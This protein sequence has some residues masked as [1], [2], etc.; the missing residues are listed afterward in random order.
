MKRFKTTGLCNPAK[1]YMVDISER[2]AQ[3]KKMVDN[4][5]YFTINRARQFGK[6]TTLAALKKYLSDQYTVLNLDFQSMSN[7]TFRTEGSFIKAFAL[8]LL[9]KAEINQV[10]IPEGII[11][12]FRT[13]SVT[14]EAV[15]DLRMLFT[16]FIRWC[17]FS[18]KQIVV[19]IDEVDSASNNQVFLD[20]LAQ[21]RLMYL[22]REAN[23]DYPAFQS[24]ILAGVTDI[25]HLKS[26]IRDEDQI[27]VNSPWNIAAD[28]DI[29]MTLSAAGIKGMLDDY[30]SDH[31]T[32]MDTK[33]IADRI[34]KYTF[35][36]PFLVS[37]ICQLIDEKMVPDRFDS[38]EDAWTD[39]GFD[40]AIKMLLLEDNSLFD[41]LTGKL[42]NYPL[43]REKLKGILLRGNTLEYL[44]DDE[45]QKQL[46]MYG[47]VRNYHNTCV[48]FNRIFEMRLY[49]Q[50]LGESRYD[51][52]KQLGTSEKSVFIENGELNVPKIM[53]HFINSQKQIHDEY[54][55]KFAEEEGR[56][57]FL[58][59]LS[60]IIN[61]VGTY[62]IEEQTRDHRRMDIVIHYLGKRYVIELKIWRGNSY[63]EKGE[64][65]LKGYLDFFGLDVGYLLSFNF[66]KKKRSGVERI[67]IGDKTIFEGTV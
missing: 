41:S 58:T 37:R 12:E 14:D 63:N 2:L 27:K 15:L 53:E 30:E 34:Y 26:R 67:K 4:G 49:K 59:Y 46:R 1:D 29:D 9:E 65:Q 44:P 52:L 48:V 42:T 35:G 38:L 43:L 33:A 17:A 50:F 45:A 66:N 18:D 51:D 22:E 25:K 56:E 7:S 57:R 31:H 20:F 47:F 13:L 16:V 39:I 55:E 3:I 6:T 28:F 21:L 11:S 8:Y 24:V 62:S 60:P 19:F 40:E 61:G 64:E 32:G 54:T 23:T 5:D 36:Y 10:V